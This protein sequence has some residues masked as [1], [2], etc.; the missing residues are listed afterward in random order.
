MLFRREFLLLMLLLVNAVTSFHV[1]MRH[2]HAVHVPHRRRKST[3][4]AE[5][6]K[7]QNEKWHNEKNKKDY[8]ISRFDQNGTC[9]GL[10][11]YYFNN[12]S[13]NYTSFAEL[14]SSYKNNFGQ[15]ESYVLNWTEAFLC[16]VLVCVMV[17]FMHPI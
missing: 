13:N 3:S 9:S 15:R 12:L 11:Y 5:K 7:R 8:A 1:P 16:T 2:V 17:Y 6:L 14:Y 10:N 4:N